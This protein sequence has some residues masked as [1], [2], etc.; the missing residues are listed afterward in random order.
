MVLL[1]GMRSSVPVV[2]SLVGGI[3]EALGHTTWTAPPEDESL[4]TEL[5]R[6]LLED[7]RERGSW[8]ARLRQRFL[9][10]FTLETTVDRYCDVYKEVLAK[11]SQDA[12]R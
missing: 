4:L 2:A 12:A 11:R 9:E 5:V 3:P 8:G 1:E 6:R 7:G 10:R